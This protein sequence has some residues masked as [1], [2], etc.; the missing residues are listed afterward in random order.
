MDCACHGTLA[1]LIVAAGE[2]VMLHAITAFA[3]QLFLAAG[4][5]IIIM[6]NA[7]T[8]SGGVAAAVA[9]R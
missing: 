9:A 2:H 5:I 6:L 4:D 8:A 7:I 1:H 3:A